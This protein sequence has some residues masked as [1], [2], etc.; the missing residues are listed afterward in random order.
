VDTRTRASLVGHGVVVILLGLL[1]GFPYAL[2]ISGD[3]EGEL[4]AWRMA[5]MEGVLNGLVMLGVGAAGG[6]IAL[7]R[8]QVR[9]MEWGLLVAGYGNVVAASLGAFAG[10]RGLAPSGP[11]V[12]LLVFVLFTAA[13]VGVLLGLGLAVV[14]AFRHGGQGAPPA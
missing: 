13:I 2:V 3:L 14:G 11:A 5:H 7:P 10:V 6:L 8:R 12:N 9:W 4:R 1:A